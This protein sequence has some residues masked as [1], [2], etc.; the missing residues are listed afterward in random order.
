MD[1]DGFTRAKC[2]APT[3]VIRPMDIS[4]NWIIDVTSYQSLQL[5]IM[6]CATRH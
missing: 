2:V 6:V 3:S 4:G 1:F 5:F